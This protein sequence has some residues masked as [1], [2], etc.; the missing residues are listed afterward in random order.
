LG[1][2][3][4]ESV[5]IIR[6]GDSLSDAL[7]RVMLLQVELSNSGISDKALKHNQ[8]L[9]EYLELYNALALAPAIISSALAREESRGAHY[10]KDYPSMSDDYTKHTNISWRAE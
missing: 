4:Y 3:M 7:D 1:R 8:N 6:D 10:R 9:V 2:L 5:G